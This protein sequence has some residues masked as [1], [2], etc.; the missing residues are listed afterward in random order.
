MLITKQTTLI[1]SNTT[2][3]YF[4]STGYLYL[5]ATS[6]DLYLDYP[7]T[8]QYKNNTKKDTTESI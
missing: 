3:V 8:C 6:F 4:N 7:Q 2:L 5:R 1:Q